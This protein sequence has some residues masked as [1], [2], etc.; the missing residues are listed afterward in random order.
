MSKKPAWAITARK[1]M[2][3]KGLKYADLGAAVGLSF[4]GVSHQF[5]GRRSVSL[6]QIRT[7]AKMLDLSLNELVGDDAVFVSDENHKKA[8]AILKEIPADKTE[9]ALKMLEALLENN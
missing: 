2:D 1:A 3:R 5:N 4:S 9:L 6:E 7:Y 8:I